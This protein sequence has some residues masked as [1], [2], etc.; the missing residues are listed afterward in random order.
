[1]TWDGGEQMSSRP[2]G[3]NQ[4]EES[5]ECGSTGEEKR[6]TWVKVSSGSGFWQLISEGVAGNLRSSCTYLGE[7]KHME[8]AGPEKSL[9]KME[10]TDLLAMVKWL[11]QL[12][13]GKFQWSWKPSFPRLQAEQDVSHGSQPWRK[14]RTPLSCGWK[15]CWWIG[16][17][18]CQRR[19]LHEGGCPVWFWRPTL[20]CGLLWVRPKSLS[21]WTS[22]RGLMRK[23][24]GLC[25]SH[26]GEKGEERKMF[27]Q[28]VI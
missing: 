17:Q 5:V 11:S 16:A 19:S 2:G 8:G 26:W 25:Y 20:K 18:V 6:N 15:P 14:S 9:K 23:S 10:T 28:F 3:K 1:M 27:N 13:R 21:Y 12:H 4:I 7:K 24:M 22:S